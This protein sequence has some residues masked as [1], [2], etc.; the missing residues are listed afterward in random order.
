MKILGK[1]ESYIGRS[2]SE[3]IES[4]SNLLVSDSPDYPSGNEMLFLRGSI[5]YKTDPS[6]VRFKEPGKFF[7]KTGNLGETIYRDTALF[8]PLISALY[9]M[10]EPYEGRPLLDEEALRYAVRKDISE[11][12]N[13]WLRFKSNTQPTYKPVV[14]PKVKYEDF[15]FETAKFTL[16]VSRNSPLVAQFEYPYTPNNYEA[17]QGGYFVILYDLKPGTYRFNF[18]G[19]GRGFYYTAGVYD[20]TVLNE[21]LRNLAND[22]S[23]Q[24]LPTNPTV[25]AQ[26]KA[27][28][29][30]L[31]IEDDIEKTSPF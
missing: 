14:L 29:F 12:G 20:I 24:N 8:I 30:H 18:G 2:Y 15:Y 4:W 16:N 31:K 11:G 17:V 25:I 13:M 7:D 3:W 26:A 1:N 22:I 23:N 6:G 19:F 10:N 5:D 21:T 28:V 27:K 9:T